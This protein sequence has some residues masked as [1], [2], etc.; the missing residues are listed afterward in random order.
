[1]RE[2][3]WIAYVVSLHSLKVDFAL[4]MS[5]SL[6]TNRTDRV[7]SPVAIVAMGIELMVRA[8]KSS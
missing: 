3:L 5:D 8:H 7:E 2:I 4:L 1:L 6:E